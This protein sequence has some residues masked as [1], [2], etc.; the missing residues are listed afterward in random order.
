MSSLGMLQLVSP[1][2]PVGGFCYSEGLEYLVQ[3][4]QITNEST[5]KD[6]LTAE[7]LRGQDRIEAAAQKQLREHLIKWNN[8]ESNFHK[9]I[10]YEWNSWLLALRYA[11]EMRKQQSQMGHSLLELLSDLGHPLP[12]KRNDH[13][14]PIAWSW[15]GLAWDISLSELIRGYLYNWVANQL[16]AAVRLIPLGPTKAQAV[17]FS[18]S[19]LIKGQA[20]F[21]EKQ[22][23]KNIWTADIGATMA[24]QSHEELYS[25]LFRS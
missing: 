21:L 3:E 7:L 1:A 23:P 6:W 11:P 10:V 5:I 24:Q 13:C 14:W 16:S 18:L 2:L 9:S 4:N 8:S 22:N 12:N 19:N 15:A 20:E 25:K 17:Q